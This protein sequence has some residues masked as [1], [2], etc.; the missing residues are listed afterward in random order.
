[1]LNFW[2]GII[3]GVV[4]VYIG[5]WIGAVLAYLR[6]KYMMRDLVELFAQRYPIV[7]AADQVFEKK[8]FK[9]MLLLRLCPIIPFNG[10]NYIGGIV[11]ISLKDYCASLIG[12]LPTIFLWVYV[13]ASADAF[14]NRSIDD[15]DDNAQAYAYA[16]IAT[17]IVFALVALV[18]TWKYAMDELK[19]EVD[20]ETWYKYRSKRNVMEEGQELTLEMYQEDFYTPMSFSWLGMEMHGLEAYSEGPVDGHDESLWWLWT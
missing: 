10:L 12:I 18:L 20:A 2:F 9:L 7:K 17:G 4:V 19:R 1:M 5:S 11:S 15:G 6:S 16:L 14:T 13:G 3:V 8:G